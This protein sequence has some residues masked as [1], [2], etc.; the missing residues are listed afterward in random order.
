M[1]RIPGFNPFSDRRLIQFGPSPYDEKTEPLLESSGNTLA[2]QPEDSLEHTVPA[3]RLTPQ[4]IHEIFSV[5]GHGPALRADGRKVK[6]TEKALEFIHQFDE[7]IDGGITALEAVMNIQGSIVGALQAAQNFEFDS[8]EITSR[9]MPKAYEIEH[10][11]AAILWVD[12]N[13]K[14]YYF[15]VQPRTSIDKGIVDKA[16]HSLAIEAFANPISLSNS[17]TYIPMEELQGLTILADVEYSDMRRRIPLHI[18][19]KAL[20]TFIEQRKI[21]VLNRESLA[22]I[23]GRQHGNISADQILF[24]SEISIANKLMN[25]QL[26]IHAGTPT[27]DRTQLC[28]VRN[29]A[30]F[31]EGFS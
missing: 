13:Q 23:A 15:I 11:P 3:D 19:S 2:G 12:G 4:R 29:A 16:K 22:A 10:R 21:L 9:R 27:N 26:L 30:I 18:S 5:Y 8:E 17:E 24:S 28:I 20:R 7:T 14:R 1:Q 25:G 6:L 31:L